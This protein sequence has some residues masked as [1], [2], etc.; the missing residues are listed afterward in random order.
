MFELQLEMW[1][2]VTVM[3][4]RL[5]GEVVEVDE[6]L[7]QD[8]DDLTLEEGFDDGDEVPSVLSR[9]DDD[10]DWDMTQT[11]HHNWNYCASCH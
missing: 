2:Q 1:L 7:F 6:S 4:C 8:I 11:G 9:N 3:F 10:D 5:G